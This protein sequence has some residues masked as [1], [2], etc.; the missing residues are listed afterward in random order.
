[1]NI[2]IV[3]SMREGNVIRLGVGF[4]CI[5]QG[6]VTSSIYFVISSIEIEWVRA[7]EIARSILNPD[8]LSNNSR[9]Q[10]TNLSRL[11]RPRHILF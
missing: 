2:S 9:H 3:Y 1:M 8:S 10:L 6:M 5:Y 11:Q 7:V 4:A